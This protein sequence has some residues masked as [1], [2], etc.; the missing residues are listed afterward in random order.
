MQHIIGRMEEM[1]GVEA[2]C[3]EFV[4]CIGTRTTPSSSPAHVRS[5][6]A[7][8]GHFLTKD[9]N[10]FAYFEGRNMCKEPRLERSSSYIHLAHA[11]E[12]EDVQPMSTSLGSNGLRRRCASPVADVREYSM[13]PVLNPKYLFTCTVGRMESIARYNDAWNA[14]T[15]D[16]RSWRL[17]LFMYQVFVAEFGGGGGYPGRHR[18]V[19]AS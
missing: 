14:R 5:V 2:V 8:L 9:E 15:Y 3:F 10:I 1:L 7:C 6:C 13:P 12:Q 11:G 16:H 19:H 4:L 18:T 17:C